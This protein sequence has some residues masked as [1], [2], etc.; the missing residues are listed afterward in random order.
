MECTEPEGDQSIFDAYFLP[1]WWPPF[2]NMFIN[3]ISISVF[4]LQSNSH[5]FFFLSGSVILSEATGNT[6]SSCYVDTMYVGKVLLLS[7][8]FCVPFSLPHRTRLPEYRHKKHPHIRPLFLTQNQNTVWL[9][10]NEK[11]PKCKL[12]HNFWNHFLGKRAKMVHLLCG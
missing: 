4:W 3:C 6:Y 11:L 2:Q 10:S 9:K 5:F 7:S 12:H 1:F 8:L